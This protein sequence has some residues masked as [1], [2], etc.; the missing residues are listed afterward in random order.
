MYFGAQK[1]FKPLISIIIPTLNE[2]ANV[3]KILQFFERA[4]ISVPIEV[5]I[6][7]SPLST[8]DIHPTS[9]ISYCK[10]F[11]TDSP[12]RATQMNAGANKAIGNIF[13]FLHADVLPPL[14]FVD[15]IHNAIQNGYNFGLFAYSFE[16]S[17]FWLRINAWFTN[18]KGLFVGGGDQIHFMTKDIFNLLNGYN[19]RYT[20]ME[21]FDFMRR[22]KKLDQPYTIIQNR[23]IVSSRKYENNTWIKVNLV[24]LY[25]MI[26][27]WTGAPSEA[28][29]KMY[30][31]HL[32][33]LSNK[34]VN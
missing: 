17:T 5:I 12:G 11:T 16:P 29:R 18:R 22:Y 9:S 7:D 33:P 1:I 10:V 8:D 13:V 26:L 30:N 2:Q 4:S 34:E 31:K 19:E 21:D 24:N 27:F 32:V 15:D 20:L 14:S 6:A 28:I 23:A 3:T 25:A